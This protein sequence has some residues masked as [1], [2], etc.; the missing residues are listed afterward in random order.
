VNVLL[1]AVLVVLIL[2][3]GSAAAVVVA[4]RW[5]WKPL[6]AQ[7]VVVQL[8]TDHAVSGVLIERR[9]PLLILADAHVHGPDGQNVKAD[10]RT[11]IE[12]SRVLWVQVI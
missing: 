9:G 4:R 10:G 12:R 7:R 11:V 3:L 2:L 8:D 1:A 5:V 6:V